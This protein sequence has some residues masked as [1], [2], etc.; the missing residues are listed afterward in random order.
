MAGVAPRT[1]RLEVIELNL[2]A[3]G[4]GELYMLRR[5][6]EDAADGEWTSTPLKGFWYQLA[7]QLR[8]V[9]QWRAGTM[10]QQEQD[11]HSSS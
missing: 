11:F 4:D 9:E 6:F 3:V 2:A 1:P 7:R 10:L 8:S 5:M